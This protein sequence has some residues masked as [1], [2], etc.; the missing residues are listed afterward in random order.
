MADGCCQRVRRIRGHRSIQF[1][2]A[3]HHQ[4]DL[5]LFGVSGAN[6]GLLDL[7][8]RIFKD[9]RLGIGGTANGRAARLAQFQGAVGVAIDEHFFDGDFLRLILRDDGLYAAENFA[10][11]GGKI[12]FGGVND[13]AGHVG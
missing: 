1:E 6:H 11:A 10:Q 7:T 5:A 12:G 8:R 3:S 9:P 2:Y 4:L 13:A